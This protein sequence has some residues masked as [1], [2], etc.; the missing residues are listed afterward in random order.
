MGGSSLKGMT[1]NDGKRWLNEG[2]FVPT[3]TSVEDILAPFIEQVGAVT[4]KVLATI[5]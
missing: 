2:E 1:A 3:S 5:F 4:P